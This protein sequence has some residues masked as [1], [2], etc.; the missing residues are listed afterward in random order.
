MPNSTGDIPPSATSLHGSADWR[1]TYARLLATTDAIAII[2]VVIAVQLLRFGLDADP[3]IFAEDLASIDLSYWS[4]SLVIIAAWILMLGVYK[5]RD[6]R[7]VGSGTLEYKRVADAS[8]R[9]FGLVAIAA[10]LFKVDL[11]RGYVLLRVA[12]HSLA[13]AP[14]A[15]NAAVQRAVCVAPDPC[16]HLYKQ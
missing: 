9:L 13:L 14:V 3:T 11:A 12:I 15:V 2:W 10:F 6:Y 16:R 1:S 4:I 5:S 8:I 7:V